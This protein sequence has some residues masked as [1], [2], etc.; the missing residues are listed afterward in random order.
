MI[1][2]V[3]T[4]NYETYVYTMCCNPMLVCTFICTTCIF[5]RTCVG[6]R[7]TVQSV[8]VEEMEKS[9]VLV[10]WSLGDCLLSPAIPP[11]V[12]L[13]GV[14]GGSRVSGRPNTDC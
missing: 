5:I 12:E 2:L 8:S 7:G 11:D 6:A 13:Q 4:G 9:T 1:L 10:G 3:K 14:G